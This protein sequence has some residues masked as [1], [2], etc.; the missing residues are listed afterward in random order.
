M[1]KYRLAVV[2]GRFQP[3]HNGHVAL[4]RRAGELA[5]QVLAIVGSAERPRS[6]KNPWTATER[7]VMLME[8]QIQLEAKT[9]A[10]YR[11]EKN[12]DSIYNNAAWAS[13]IQKIV[14]ECN[15]P[16]SEI[17]LVGHVKD[18][19]S[20]YLKMFPQWKF[21]EMPLVEPL[22]ATQIRDIYFSPSSN[23]NFIQG[24]VPE[25][26]LKYLTAFRKKS[27]YQEIVAERE[28]LMKY[29]RQFEN[30]PYPPIFVTADAVV[31]QSGHVL[32]VRRGAQP[33]RGLW[34]L[35][36][37]FVNA[38]T[39]ASVLDAALR[40]LREETNIKVPERVLRGSLNNSRVFDAPDRSQRGRTITH[41]FFFHLQ[42][43]EWNLP[44][45]RGSDDAADAVWMP[46]GKLNPAE[47][48]E[49]HADI[50]DYFLG[51]LE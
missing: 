8:T 10:R 42:D 29:R 44:R 50:I 43:G 11:Y 38:K 36:G 37:G 2:I 17:V 19:S 49:D 46:I 22:D 15:I 48:F 13:R 28:F 39:D 4:L 6:Y 32:M 7:G 47:I 21:E 34:A 1:K 25:F 45:I 41:A 16:D 30:L 14:A 33:G 9:G 24:V 27:A 3:V 51:A 26:T 12:T 18:A 23:L 5:D 40:E 20:F 35:P 31:V